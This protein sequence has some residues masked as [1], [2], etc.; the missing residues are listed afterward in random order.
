MDVDTAKER[1]LEPDFPLEFLVRG[2]PVSLQA[3]R[4]ESR[5]KWK[6]RVRMASRVVLPE[7]HW[8]TTG[9]VAVTLFYFPD[10]AIS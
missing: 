6:E 3:K 1:A 5:A 8:A 7:G 10:A 9:G 2:T 4:A